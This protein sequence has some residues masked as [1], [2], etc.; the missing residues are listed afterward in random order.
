MSAKKRKEI[1]KKA[2]QALCVSSAASNGRA[3]IAA[4]ERR[5]LHAPDVSC[6]HELPTVTPFRCA[7]IPRKRLSSPT[8]SAL[9]LRFGAEFHVGR[10]W[11]AG[12]VLFVV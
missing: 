7:R 9:S 8:V 12:G 1:A 2:A 6:T 11:N 3:N 4:M 10:Q 5:Q